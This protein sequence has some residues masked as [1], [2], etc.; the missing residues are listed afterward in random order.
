MG[1]KTWT[2][3]F[4]IMVN[5]YDDKNTCS[6][7]ILKWP[8]YPS[9]QIQIGLGAPLPPPRSGHGALENEWYFK[10]TLANWELLLSSLLSWRSFIWPHFHTFDF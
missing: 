7:V 5:K 6:P 4:N 8:P 10:A 1:V 9:D 2:H 3:T